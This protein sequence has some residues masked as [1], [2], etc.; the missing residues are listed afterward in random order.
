MSK[1][2]QPTFPLRMTQ[3]QRN[4]VAEL[5]AHLEPKLLLDCGNQRTL[6]L[7]LEEIKQIAEACQAALPKARNGMIRNSLRHVLDASERAVEA[8][9][10]GKIHRMRRGLPDWRTQC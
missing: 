2:D 4:C 8:F 7:T 3:A 6:Q 9:S 10:E 5:L 1:I